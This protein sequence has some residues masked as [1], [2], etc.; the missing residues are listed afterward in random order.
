MPFVPGTLPDPPEP[1]ASPETQRTV[2]KA[3]AG[4]EDQGVRDA[5]AALGR[6]IAG[7]SR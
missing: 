2:G 3:V 5:L 1:E 7:R 6:K 4:V